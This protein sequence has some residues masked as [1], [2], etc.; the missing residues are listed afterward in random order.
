MC[1]E[2]LITVHPSMPKQQGP[3]FLPCQGPVFHVRIKPSP[4]PQ[5]TALWMA[6]VSEV[7]SISETAGSFEIHTD[8]G[9]R[10]VRSFS[11]LLYSEDWYAPFCSRC[12]MLNCFFAGLIRWCCTRCTREDKSAEERWTSD[13]IKLVAGRRIGRKNKKGGKQT[14]TVEIPNGETD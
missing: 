3:P 4:F 6:I 14:E 10:Y 13:W 7:Y 9:Q 5:Q 1:A 2:V 8:E 12:C 11:L